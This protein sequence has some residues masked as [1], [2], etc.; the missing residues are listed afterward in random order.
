MLTYFWASVNSSLRKMECFYGYLLYRVVK[1]KIKAYH[2][3]VPA[4][5]QKICPFLGPAFLSKAL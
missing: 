2:Y 5:S 4:S 3:V 1:M